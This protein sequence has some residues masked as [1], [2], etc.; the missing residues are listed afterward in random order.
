MAQIALLAKLL[1]DN[2]VADAHGPVWPLVETDDLLFLS[3]IY[4]STL[5]S[6]P[7]LLSE[8]PPTHPDPSRILQIIDKYKVATLLISGDYAKLLIRSD[9]FAH[10]WEGEDDDNQW[11]TLSVKK[12]FVT[13]PLRNKTEEIAEALKKIFPEAEI[14]SLFL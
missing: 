12:V 6:L 14:S 2:F 1:A 10:L 7:L 3:S 13:S 8:A 11:S 9:E 4:A 5:A